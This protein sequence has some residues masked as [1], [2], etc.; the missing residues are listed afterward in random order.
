M[1]HTLSTIGKGHQ[2]FT[3]WLYYISVKLAVKTS[4]T[5]LYVL[6]W[7]LAKAQVSS[8]NTKLKQQDFEAGI[9]SAFCRW[10]L[11]EVMKLNLGRDSEARF[12][13]RF[14]IQVEWGFWCLVEIFSWC[15]VEILKMKS[16]KDL[17]LNLWYDLKKLLRQDERNPR[18]RCA[19]G[20]VL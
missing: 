5:K 19:F 13:S 8:Q 2:T 20:N 12:W 10:W 1:L 18:V 15:L 17:C 16:D 7:Y 4:E 3:S 9:C 11:V 14:W 6:I